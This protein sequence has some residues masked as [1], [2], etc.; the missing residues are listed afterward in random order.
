M[1]WK[2]PIHRP[3]GWTPPAAGGNDPYYASTSWK[4]LRR[5]VLATRGRVCMACGEVGEVVD[6]IVPRKRGGGD[7]ASNLQVL[8]R[9]CHSTKSAK[10]GSR[11]GFR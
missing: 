2:P 1:P 10:E 4:R 6:H 11:W 7:H 3:P 5:A 8:C 9:S